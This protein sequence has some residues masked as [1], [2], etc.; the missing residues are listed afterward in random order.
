MLFY[1]KLYIFV[2]LCTF[3]GDNDNDNSVGYDVYH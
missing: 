3:A 1:N 2:M